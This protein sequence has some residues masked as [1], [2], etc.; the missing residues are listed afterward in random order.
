MLV[1]THHLFEPLPEVMQDAALIDRLHCYLP[2][3]EMPKMD[4]AMLTSHYGFIVDYLAEAFRYLRRL[5]FTELVDRPFVLG[6]HLNK[7]DDT[8][9]R[10]CVS[11]LIKI[12]H[13]DQ[14]YSPHELA[15]YLTLALELRRRVKE[16]LK[17]MLPFEY[18]RTSFSFIERESQQEHFVACPEEG[19]RELIPQDPLPPGTVYTAAV[20]GA[21][22]KA[23]VYRIEVTTATGTGKLKLS[24]GIDKDFREACQRAFSYVQTHK[25]E[26]GLGREI[27]AHDFFV[28]GVD[29]L[30]SR[31]P[32]EPGVA[33]FVAAVSALRQT[34]LQG[35]TV[36]LGDMSIQG[37]IK[38]L[39]TLSELMQLSLDNGAKRVLVPTANRRQALE[40]EEKLLE[41]ASFYN[42]P[43]G[44]VERAVGVR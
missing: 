20:G 14:R 29:L 34:Q 30:G 39:P 35:G 43:M 41:L 1:K 32:C 31:V 25:G 24:G 17:K 19:G 22:R 15:D 2:G 36:V 5:N 26:L 38:G 44:A 21:E 9:V 37:N 11:G 13:P 4:P 40:L 10:R 12:L 27:D 8:A 23:G 42:D 28:E 7:R 3:W 33:F 16:Q 18:A 6:A